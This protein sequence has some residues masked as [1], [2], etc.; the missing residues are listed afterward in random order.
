MHKAIKLFKNKNIKRVSQSNIHPTGFY[1]TERRWGDEILNWSMTS[2]EIFNFIRAICDPAPM[3]R[4][5]INKKEIRIN[6]SEMVNYAPNYKC[7]E[8]VILGKDS[9]GVYVKTGDN[10]IKITEYEY[11]DI[12]KIGDRLEIE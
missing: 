9:T 5:Y 1:C 3:A 7:T 6:K 2:R 4:S 12:L 10:F 8:G 11:D